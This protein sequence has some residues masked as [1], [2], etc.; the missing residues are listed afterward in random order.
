M[1]C[2]VAPSQN[3]KVLSSD[4]EASREPSGENDKHFTVSV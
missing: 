4:P 2:P 1:R 3:I